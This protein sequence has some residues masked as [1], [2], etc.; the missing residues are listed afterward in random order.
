MKRAN[1]EARASQWFEDIRSQGA[2][3]VQDNSAC[4]LSILV[5]P[6]SVGFRNEYVRQLLSHGF[7]NIVWRRYQHETA[8]IEA[9][10]LNTAQPA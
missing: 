5:M 8:A 6:R 4:V 3:G 2:A 1:G 7:D 9:I 10:L